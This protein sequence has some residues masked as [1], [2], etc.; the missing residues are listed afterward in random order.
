[1]LYALGFKLYAI[2]CMLKTPIPNLPVPKGA[3]RRVSKSY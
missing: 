3:Y 2:C 1:M